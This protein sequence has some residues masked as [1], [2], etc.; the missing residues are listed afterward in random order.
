MAAHRSSFGTSTTTAEGVPATVALTV[1]NLDCEPLVGAAVYVW[2]CDRDGSY[3]LSSSGIT[4]ENY[5]RGIQETDSSGKVT[6]TS[7][8]GQP[9]RTARSVGWIGFT[10]AVRWPGSDARRQAAPSPRAPGAAALV[11]RLVALLLTGRAVIR[12]ARPMTAQRRP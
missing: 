12:L 8:H 10:D 7:T 6:F 1:Q 4:E 9:D 11:A 3:S 5:L 2:H